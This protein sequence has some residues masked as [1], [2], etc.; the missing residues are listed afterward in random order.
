MYLSN[1]TRNDYCMRLLRCAVTEVACVASV[2][3]RVIA[4]K[5]RAEAKKK[6]RWKR[7]GEGRR[8]GSFFPSPSPVIPFLFALVPTFSTNSRGNACYAGYHR[9]VIWSGYNHWTF[10]SDCSMKQPLPLISLGGLYL[11]HLTI[12]FISL[13]H[14]NAKF[15]KISS[16]KEN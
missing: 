5:V 4:R 3:N 9:R 14:C 1:S 7:E 13:Q 10:F 6:K 16:K 15:W 12:T 8:R 11:S 2:S